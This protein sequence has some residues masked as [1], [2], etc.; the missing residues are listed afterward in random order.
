MN[1]AVRRVRGLAL[2]LACVAA[3]ALHGVQGWQSAGEYRGG[4][5]YEGETRD[6]KPHGPGVMT[7]PDGQRYEGEYREDEAQGLGVKVT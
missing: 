7:W 1:A 6:G 5:H 2:L 4:Y 3:P